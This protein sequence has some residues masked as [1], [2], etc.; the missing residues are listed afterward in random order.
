MY[1]RC[2]VRLRHRHRIARQLE[3]GHLA[4]PARLLALGHPSQGLAQPPLIFDAAGAA[5]RTVVAEPREHQKDPANADTLTSCDATVEAAYNDHAFGSTRF[6]YVLISC[7]GGL[8]VDA[9]TAGTG[10]QSIR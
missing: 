8:V 5:A 9:V 2:S 3:R 1:R 4:A 7:H 6:G 10:M